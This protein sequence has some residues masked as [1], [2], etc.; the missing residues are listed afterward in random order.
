MAF[1]PARKASRA[2]ANPTGTT[3]LVFGHLITTVPNSAPLTGKSRLGVTGWRQ[4]LSPGMRAQ[5]AHPPIDE[6]GDLGVS[7]ISYD[8]SSSPTS[9]IPSLPIVFCHV[10]SLRHTC[11]C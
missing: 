8:A 4:R 6:D 1:S 7:P 3:F 11:L 2:L 9:P 5:P 10:D